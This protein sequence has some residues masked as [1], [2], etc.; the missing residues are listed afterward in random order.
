MLTALTLPAL[1][2]LFAFPGFGVKK[3]AAP[4]PTDTL[5]PPWKSASRLALEPYFVTGQLRPLRPAGRPALRLTYDPR[6]LRVEFDPDSAEVRSITEFGEVALDQGARIDLRDYAQDL[7]RA[8]F[9]RS[10][11]ERSRA[12]INTLAASGTSSQRQ[13]G[14]SFQFPS[15][16]PKRV[17][18]WLGPGGPA[19]NVSG[20]ENIKLS[21]TSNWTNQELGVLGQKRSLFPSL[22]M[23]QDLDI[24]LEGQLSD[25]IRVNL[26]QNSANQIPLANRIAINYK[27]DEDDLVQALDLGNTSL[28]LPGT[29]YVSYSGRNE[30]LFGAK[31]ATRVGP[32]DFTLLAS[33][34]EG[35][36]ERASYGGGATSQMQTIYDYDY[37]KG[38]YFFLYD[39]NLASIDIPDS[40][41]RVYVDDNNGTNNAINTVYGRAF[42]DPLGVALGDTAHVDGYFTIRDQVDYEI[43]RVYGDYFKVLRLRQPLSGNMRL[44]VSYRA[45]PAGSLGAY[46][47]QVGGEVVE[48][49]VVVFKL[50]RAPDNALGEDPVTGYFDTTR[51]L[52]RVRDLELKNFYQLSG[53]QIDPKSFELSVRR[54]VTQPYRTTVTVDGTPIPYLEMLG[55]DNLDETSGTPLPGHDNKVDGTAVQDASNS[56]YSAFVDYVNGVLFLPDPRPFAPRLTGSGARSFDQRVSR[57]LS[58]RDSLVAPADSLD[59]AN[60]EIY[61]RYNRDRNRDTQYF[62]DVTF[63]AAKAGGE[64]QLGR[65]NIIEGSDVVTINGQALTRNTDYTIDYDLG[66]VTMKR[67]VGAADNLNIDYSYAPLF[68]QA[69]RTLLGSAF[70]LE[71]RDKAFGGAFLYESRGAQDL[72]P[73]IGEEPSRSLIGDL[74]TEWSFRPGWLTRLVDRLPGVRT[75]AASDL[76]VQAEGGMSFPNPNTRNEVYIDDMEGTRDAVSLSMGPERWRNGSVPSRKQGRADVKLTSLTHVLNAEVHWFQPPTGIKEKDLRPTLEQS[77]G[78]D[79]NHQ[80]L[81]ISVP[82]RPTGSEAPDLSPTDS[83]WVSLTYPLDAVGLD[84][85]RSQFIELWV[86]DFNDRHTGTLAPRVRGRGVKLHIDVGRVSEDQMRAPKAEPNGKL[87]TEDRNLDGQ[88]SVV[89]TDYEDTGY[90]GTVSLDNGDAGNRPKEQPPKVD[91]STANDLDL[92]GDDYDNIYDKWND[93]PLNDLDPRRYIRTNGTE[94]NHLRVPIPDT[95]DLSNDGILDTREDYYEYTLDLGDAASPYLLTDVRTAFSGVAEDNGWRRYRIPMDDVARLAFGSPN[96]AMAQHV[97]VWVEG[98]ITPDPDPATEPLWIDDKGHATVRPLLVLGGLEI[99]GSRW[100]ATDLSAAL[101]AKGTTQTINTVNTQDDAGVYVPPFDPGEALSGSQTATRREQSLSLEF[102]EF[103]VDD[104]LE[105]YKAFSV[106]ENYSRYGKLDW[107]VT[108][109][110]IPGYDPARDTLWYFVRFA[111]DDNGRNYY[112]YRAPVPANSSIGHIQWSRITLPL[113]D[114]SNLK[115]RSDFPLT[116]PILYVDSS[117]TARYIV[118]GRPSFTRLRRI[119]VG[120]INGAG[121]TARRWAKGQLWI[122][123][124]RAIDVAKDVG[125]AGRLSASGNV[126]NLISYNS[127][128]SMRD[129]DFLSVGETRGGGSTTSQFNLG[130]TFQTQRFFEGT[131]ITLPVTYGFARSMSTPRYTAGDDV[132]RTGA[133]ADASE[134]YSGTHTLGMSYARSWSARANPLLRYTVGGLTASTNRT[135]SAGHNPTNV[136]KRTSTSQNVN[137]EI[138]PRN[139]W[140]VGLPLTKRKLYPLPERVYWRYAMQSSIDSTWDRVRGAE[141]SLLLRTAANGRQATVSFGGDSRPVDLFHHHFEGVRNLS[142]DRALLE[143]GGLLGSINFGRVVQWSQGMDAN[144]TLQRGNWLKP[145]LSWSSSYGQNNGPELS[146]DLSVRAVNNTQGGRLSWEIPLNTLTPRSAAPARRDSGAAPPRRSVGEGLGRLLGRLGALSIDG[147]V[148]RNTS[149]SRL[150]GTPNMLYLLGL[151]DDPGLG[152]AG[153]D[154]VVA[155]LGNQSIRSLTR[156]LNVRTRIDL[157]YGAGLTTRAETTD[158]DRETNSVRTATTTLRFPDFEV[159]YGRV[160]SL[161][162]MDK[163]MNNVR[164]RTALSRSQSWDRLG[165]RMTSASSGWDLRPLFSLN[166]SF[167]NNTQAEF[168]V[169]TRS[170]ENRRYQAG[171]TRERDRKTTVNLS[172]NRSYTQGQKVNVLGR[173]SVVRTNISMG[174]TGAYELN[175]GETVRIFNGRESVPLSPKNENRLSVRGTGSYGFSSNVT[176]NA[177]I[178]FTQNNNV[179]QKIVRRSVTVELRAQ[180]TF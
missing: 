28:T 146:R 16:L 151:S 48:D 70:R 45:R 154:R 72:R 107:Y 129:A 178:G 30:G 74:N 99:V 21:G 105:V 18:S 123:E 64:I 118:K 153:G 121:V 100:R 73:R 56:T 44:A 26:L 111:S 115:L 159:D 38:Q 94:D 50:L 133:L 13:Q 176:G 83:L 96:L 68:Q 75:T 69:G 25:R 86:N 32:L 91:L 17:Q 125:K 27:G 141:D 39:P 157:G 93:Q 40:S 53:S 137:W 2:L 71:G 142:L 97:R 145:R 4:A 10:W 127:A 106:D 55:L 51:P 1:G 122:D 87:D 49:S 63:T 120:L 162:R 139:D 79:N 103:D 47:I 113:T 84:L 22:D 46:D 76:R 119:S 124:F 177:S 61:E 24:R 7:G 34:Q 117:R 164:L 144:Y 138:S 160:P 126:A 152:E 140:A 62:I 92:A 88:L 36:S 89:D 163:L 8:G 114:L 112:E 161:L 108:G 170:T 156:N 136:S 95:E 65:G 82:R 37:V 33:K 101:V 130:G 150:A 148:S 43:L 3:P 85:S 12:Q 15:P 180:F 171:E 128:F 6:K 132:V 102:N 169:D 168:K 173:E 66:R 166:G 67:N 149:F 80:A 29:Q 59:G 5:P 134:T 104:T 172:L 155:Q 31:V 14:F 158:Q 143:K 116:D 19:L 35:R 147:S 41:L 58:R 81:A 20:S 165:G 167:R 42:A 23:Q 78:A 77:Q 179:Q 54:D 98:I 60:L 131:G 110:D 57:V 109:Y 11:R 90:D 52:D 174:M 135:W 9:E 175:S